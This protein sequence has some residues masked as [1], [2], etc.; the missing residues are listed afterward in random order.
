ME[1]YQT[2]SFSAIKPSCHFS[3]AEL[4][5]TLQK[6]NNK[7]L[8]TTN[9]NMCLFYKS[10]L[11]FTLWRHELNFCNCTYPTFSD[12]FLYWVAEICRF[13]LCRRYSWPLA[14]LL[15]NNIIAIFKVKTF[16]FWSQFKKS[17]LLPWPIKLGYKNAW[18]SYWRICI[19]VFSW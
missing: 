18:Q 14:G 15:R 10:N 13:F 8:K 4:F 16:I 17:K 6:D 1:M 5:Q 9:S 11:H 7:F 19:I 3:R 12:F 2:C